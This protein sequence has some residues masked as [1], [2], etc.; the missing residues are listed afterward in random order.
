MK[1]LQGRETTP[2]A[3]SC[4][5]TCFQEA[6]HSKEEETGG[7]SSGVVLIS[8]R[9]GPLAPVR[10]RSLS[11]SGLLIQ[12]AAEA[13]SARSGIVVTFHMDPCVHHV[14]RAAG[15]E[16][17]AMRSIAVRSSAL[18]CQ[19]AACTFARIC[20]GFVAPLM[21]D[22]TTRRANNQEIASSSIE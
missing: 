8:F 13:G 21:T 17:G 5:R 20:S 9:R 12:I 22:A 11:I 2:A 16:T 4:S 14:P 6:I 15:H 19:L 18:K 7:T 1:S 10:D 3:D